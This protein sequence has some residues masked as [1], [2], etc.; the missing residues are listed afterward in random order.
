MLFS[1]TAMLALLAA[2]AM[3]PGA[4]G[5]AVEDAARC[6]SVFASSGGSCEA[7]LRYSTCVS[8]V[9]AGGQLPSA[10]RAAAQANV[11]DAFKANPDCDAV[12]ASMVRL[13]PPLSPGRAKPWAVTGV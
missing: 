2:L 10:E 9:V 11:E 6:K 1:A 3:A 13:H 5:N 12:L 8:N 4:S 7:L